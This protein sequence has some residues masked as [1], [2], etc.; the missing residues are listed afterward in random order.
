MTQGNQIWTRRLIKVALILPILLV[1]G[2][3]LDAVKH[4]QGALSIVVIICSGL[5]LGIYSYTPK[6]STQEIERTKDD[7]AQ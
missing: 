6:Q 4:G 3:S 2:V 7:S 1:L 5:I